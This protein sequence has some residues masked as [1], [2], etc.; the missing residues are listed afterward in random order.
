MKIAALDLGS[1]TFLLLIVEI[2]KGI[3][4]FCFE[5]FSIP[6]RSRRCVNK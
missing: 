4:F 1:N 2:E 5:F 3:K 6:K